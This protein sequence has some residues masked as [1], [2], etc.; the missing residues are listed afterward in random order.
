MGV[1][2]TAAQASAVTLKVPKGIQALALVLL[3]HCSY[4]CRS[5]RNAS[6][7]RSSTDA[8]EKKLVILFDPLIKSGQHSL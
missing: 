1:V 2:S 4:Y 7:L 3:I 8:N 5:N 6:C